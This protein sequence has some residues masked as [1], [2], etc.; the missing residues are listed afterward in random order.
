MCHHLGLPQGHAQ[1]HGGVAVLP[2]L[3]GPGH[4]IHEGLLGLEAGH[5]LHHDLGVEG[6]DPAV[7]TGAL[8]LVVD[9][10]GPS[11]DRG[12]EVQGAGVAHGTVPHGQLGGQRPDVEEVPPL[13]E[14]VRI[15]SLAVLGQHLAHPGHLM[16]AAQ[17][18]QSHLFGVVVDPVTA[19]GG[20]VPEPFGRVG[21]LLRHRLE[22]GPRADSLG[23]AR[24]L[25]HRGGRHVP[26][27]SAEISVL[28]GN[29]RGDGRHL[30]HTGQTPRVHASVFGLVGELRLRHDHPF[31]HR[32]RTR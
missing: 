3:P 10:A 30:G 9:D 4:R 2:R 20:V 5:Q 22:L 21:G 28:L 12:H 32:Q 17:G 24:I 18:A 23:Q 13:V 19:R 8:G 11:A 27:P 15:G 26:H 25:D 29:H 16:R 1:Q 7:T 6:L 14:A 31:S